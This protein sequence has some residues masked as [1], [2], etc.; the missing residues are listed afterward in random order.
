[1]NEAI[2]RIA[3][4][5]NFP[6]RDVKKTPSKPKRKPRIY[7]TGR[8]QHLGVKA[9]SQTVERFY[10]AADYREVTLGRLLELALDALDREGDRPGAGGKTVDPR[11]GGPD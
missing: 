6:S 4:E 8:N 7:R 5:H 10:K 11:G 9:T 1:V 2:D 3:K